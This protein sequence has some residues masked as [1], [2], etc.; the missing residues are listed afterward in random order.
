MWCP[1]WASS[2]LRPGRDSVGVLVHLHPDLVDEVAGPLEHFLKDVLGG[3]L[4]RQLASGSF[5]PCCALMLWQPRLLGHTEQG[6]SA[7][8]DMAIEWNDVRVL[9]H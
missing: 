5:L 8:V 7:T 4:Q 9:Q 3:A 6:P 1:L 2:Y